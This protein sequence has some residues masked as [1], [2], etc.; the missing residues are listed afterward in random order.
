MKGILFLFPLL[1]FASLESHFKKAEGKT[2]GHSMR[3]IDFIYMINL[4]QRPEKFERS[5]AQLYLYGVIPYRFSAVNGWEL[6]LEEINDVGVL[7]S[8]GM[9]GGFWAT[10]YRP[11]DPDEL[12]FNEVKEPCLN[13]SC[14]CMSPFIWHHEPIQHYGLTYFAH[15]SSKG[16]IGIALSHLSVLQDAY[17]S[18]YQTIW[19][20]EDDI[21]VIRN[22]QI[23]SYLIP[24][25]DA[26][27]GVDGWDV[28]F[29]DRDIKDDQGQYIPCSYYAKRPNFSPLDPSKFSQ[30]YDISP[31]FRFV[32][33]RY[34]AQSMIVRRSGMEKILNFIKEYHIFLPYDMDYTLPPGIKLFTVRED[35]VATLTHNLSDNSL[36]KYLDTHREDFK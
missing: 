22:P 14:P 4:D 26:L 9:E 18:G 1:L 20:M 8:P 3:N 25:L 6:T 11:K 27:V 12:F 24:Q 5:L 33:S 19:V 30:K 28:L 21:E 2:G 29:T 15:C 36:P 17:D 10:R 32:G 34:G 31:D 13:P 35:V 7:F 23:L 16:M